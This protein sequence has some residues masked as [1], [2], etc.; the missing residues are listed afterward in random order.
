MCVFIKQAHDQCHLN[1]HS[2]HLHDQTQFSSNISMVKP[3][4]DGIEHINIMH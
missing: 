4:A 1:A 2:C 3:S